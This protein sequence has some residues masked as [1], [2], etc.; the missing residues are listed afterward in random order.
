MIINGEK[1]DSG[2]AT[3]QRSQLSGMTRKEEGLL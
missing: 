1:G 2:N 3:V